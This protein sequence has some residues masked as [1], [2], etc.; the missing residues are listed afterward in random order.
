MITDIVKEIEDIVTDIRYSHVERVN[1]TINKIKQYK[2]QKINQYE[3]DNRR[4]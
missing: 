2:K 4:I 1:K 3:A